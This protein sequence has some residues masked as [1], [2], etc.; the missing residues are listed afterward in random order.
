MNACMTRQEALQLGT[1]LGRPLTV[2]GSAEPVHRPP[3]LLV[4]TAKLSPDGGRYTAHSC[5]S[6]VAAL[7]QNKQLERAHRLPDL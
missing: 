1:P 2:T 5:L 6:E 4:G 3:G 7:C